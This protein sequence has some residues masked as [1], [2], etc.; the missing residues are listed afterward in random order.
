M[1]EIPHRPGKLTREQQRA[2]KQRQ[3]DFAAALKS[4]ARAA[5]WRYAGGWIFRQSG[6]WF[7]DVLPWLLP[8]RGAGL[9]LLIKPMALDPLFWDIVG[10]SENHSLP[11]S[12]RANGAWVLRPATIDSQ[13]G[14]DQADVELLATE[15][16]GVADRQ[17]EALLETMSLESML[18]ALPDKDDLFGQQR[19]LAI[20]LLILAGQ[21]ETAFDLCR[22]SSSED[23]PIVRGSGFLTR[24]PDGSVSTFLD[25]A[26][27]WIA[28]ERRGALRIV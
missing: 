19:V 27:D 25:Q 2:V 3:K 28:R 15:V 4:Q 26:R 23:H 13:A 7:V 20:C 10:A 1:D 21:T 9:R 17:T 18:A 6:D 22:I 14:L 16:L 12:F 24:N 5:H 8:E 11:L